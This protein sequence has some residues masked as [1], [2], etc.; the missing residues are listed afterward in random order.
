MIS[1]ERHDTCLRIMGE[2]NQSQVAKLAQTDDYRL[3]NAVDCID[4]SQVS[5]IDSAGVALLVHWYGQQGGAL[6]FTGVSSQLIDLANLYDLPIFSAEPFNPAS[7][8]Q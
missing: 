7:A 1:T 8:D 4:L 6:T 3:D 2:L 5:F